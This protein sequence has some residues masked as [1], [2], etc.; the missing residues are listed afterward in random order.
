MIID[1]DRPASMTEPT[2]PSRLVRVLQVAHQA[3]DM[4][5]AVLLTAT[6]GLAFYQIVL[7][8]VM[9]TGIVWGDILIRLMVLWLGMAGAMAATRQR[10]HISVDLVT[11]FLS[12]G[13]RRVA[14]GL[15]T[16]FAGSVCLAACY[17]CLQF[18]KSEY[19][20]G[21]LAF[22]P[23]PYWVCASILPLAFLIMALRYV[24]QFALILTGRM[25]AT[26]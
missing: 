16:C 19:E 4:I 22:G 18:V 15:T 23:V 25:R 24:I 13:G 2:S 3:E 12:P 6:M 14:E 20:A 5:I 7:R 17:Y 10:K 26:S 9:G 11:R 1:P 21:G 8:N